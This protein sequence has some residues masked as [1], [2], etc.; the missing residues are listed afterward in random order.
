MVIAPGGLIKQTIVE[1]TVPA[2]EWDIDNAIITPISLINASSFKAIT[3]FNAPR[4]PITATAYAKLKLPFFEMYR[5]PSGIKGN[6]KSLRSVAEMDHAKKE[7]VWRFTTQRRIWTFR[8][9]I[10]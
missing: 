9:L 10:F 6:F 2:E 8:Q 7:N 5:E 4:T 3:G 1:D